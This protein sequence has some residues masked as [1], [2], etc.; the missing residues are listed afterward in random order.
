MTVSKRRRST[1]RWWW[2][3]P[4]W[5]M[6][7]H[8]VWN[9]R[10][11]RIVMRIICARL[12]AGRGR[13]ALSSTGIGICSSGIFFSLNGSRRHSR[14]SNMLFFWFFPMFCFDTVNSECWS[15]HRIEQAAAA[16]LRRILLGGHGGR[17]E[18]KAVSRY[19]YW[20]I[21]S[22]VEKAGTSRLGCRWVRRLYPVMLWHDALG[23]LAFRCGYFRR[24]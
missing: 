19:R 3:A 16:D 18:R 7:R 10:R 11:I 23:W 15:G 22:F 5:M 12:A 9:R 20:S 13:A 4:R 14:T 17:T 8:S 24:F 21:Y 6:M 1:R 2:W